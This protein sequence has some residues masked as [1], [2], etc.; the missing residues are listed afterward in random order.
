MDKNITAA[1]L[2][3]AR[4]RSAYHVE[5]MKAGEYGDYTV[6]VQK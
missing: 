5:K 1:V 3:F 6:S 2:K 4:E